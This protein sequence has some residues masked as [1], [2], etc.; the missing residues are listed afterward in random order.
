MAAAK[1]VVVRLQRTYKQFNASERAAFPYEEAKR[2]II[3]RV[4]VLEDGNVKLADL[5]ITDNGKDADVPDA[6]SYS[7]KTHELT[8]HQVYELLPSVKTLEEL[9]MLWDGEKQHPNHEGGRKGVLAAMQE[10]AQELKDELEKED[11]EDS[12]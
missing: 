7:T 3:K 6:E 9:Q 5:G 2:L 10:R 11:E 8:A 1:T 12:D 4:A